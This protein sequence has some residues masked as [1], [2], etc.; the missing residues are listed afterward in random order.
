[1]G[2]LIEGQLLEEGEIFCR[3]RR[4]RAQAEQEEVCGVD[5][6]RA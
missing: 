2:L 3:E 1:V 5:E 4:L 6:Q